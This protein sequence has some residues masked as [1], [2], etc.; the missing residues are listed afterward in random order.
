MGPVT[1]HSMARS[2]VS[3]AMPFM[4]GHENLVFEQQCLVFGHAVREIIQELVDG[5]VKAGWQVVGDAADTHIA[6]CYARAADHLKEVKD[7][8]AFA[9]HVHEGSDPTRRGR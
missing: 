3:G 1:E 5:G 9:E 7:F 6:E 4:R 8:L 2:P